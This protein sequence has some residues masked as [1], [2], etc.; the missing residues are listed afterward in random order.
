M[1]G[2]HYAS[3]HYSINAARAYTNWEQQQ[4]LRHSSTFNAS[5]F[6]Q[7]SAPVSE[8]GENLT[9]ISLHLGD[10][11]LLYTN[12]VHDLIADETQ[13]GLNNFISFSVASAPAT[14]KRYGVSR[15]EH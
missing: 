13:S 6:D 1:P 15:G 9:A 14:H 4:P 8:T 10:A 5:S 7:C 2:S 12:L 3:D 11:F